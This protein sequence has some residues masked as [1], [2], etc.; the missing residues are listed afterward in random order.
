MATYAN[1]LNI[2][3]ENPL[4]PSFG[5]KI[6]WIDVLSSP[7]AMAP[8]TAYLADF[9]GLLIF[10]LPVTSDAGTELIVAGAPGSGGWIINQN[11]GQSIKIGTAS[12]TPTTGSIASR[13][14]SDSV[15]LVCAIDNTTWI[16]VGAP[17]SAGLV[18][19]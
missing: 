3:P 14:P 4:P 10:T 19:I 7:Q 12:S 8:D 13:D 5:G 18:I 17:Q 6:G 2:N 11:S 16:T 15:V 1:A 9:S